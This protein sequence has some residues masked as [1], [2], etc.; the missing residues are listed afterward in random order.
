VVQNPDNG[1]LIINALAI[2]MEWV[3]QFIFDKTYGEIFHLDNGEQM[4][5][6][7]MFIKE[8]HSNSISY[9]KDSKI[10]KNYN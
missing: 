3:Y 9:Y 2:D 6:T 5:A 8:V 7:M 10:I 1:M 4:S